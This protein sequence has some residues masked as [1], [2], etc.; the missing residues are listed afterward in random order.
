MEAGGN[1][2]TP[3]ERLAA[4][5]IVL[6]EAAAP[7]ANY[8]PVVR[9][10]SLLVVSGQLP[11]RDGRLLLLGK[12]GGAVSVEQGAEAA[13]LC[14]V[15]VLAQLSVFTGGALRRIRRVVRLGGFIACEPSFIQHAAV[16]N[17]ASDF[18]VLAFGD[19]GRHARST[20]GVPSLPL[21]APVEVEGMFELADGF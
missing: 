10:G 20:I 11:L 15:N 6:P 5:G 8:V 21:D 19:D 18:A 1:G 7:V 13:R 3:E 12:L 9:T 4:A 16:M 17:G 2:A 14:M